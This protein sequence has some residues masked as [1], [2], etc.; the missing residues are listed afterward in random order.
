MVDRLPCSQFRG[1]VVA[2]VGDER[3]VALETYP[4]GARR[5]SLAALPVGREGSSSMGL[6]DEWCVRCWRQMLQLPV[7]ESGRRCRRDR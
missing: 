7:V 1:A 6:G 5:E 2:A 3:A 4:V